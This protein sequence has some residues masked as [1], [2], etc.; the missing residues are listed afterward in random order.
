MELKRI[1]DYLWEIPQSGG[2]RV[3]GR[4][5]A[6]R[7]MLDTLRNDPSLK[8]VQNVAHLPGIVG[9]SL[10]MP[11]IH[12]GYGFPIGGVAAMDVNS[13]VISPG[14]VGYDI[15]CGVRLLSIEC[16]KNEIAPKIKMLLAGLFNAIPTGIGSHNA[17]SNIS[18]K[19][20]SRILRDGASEAVSLGYGCED[21]LPTI[22]EGGCLKAAQPENVSHYAKKRGIKQLGTLG[23]GNHFL[24]ID[25]VD[26]IYDD[27]IAKTFHLRQNQVVII[28]HTGSR[29]LGHQVCDDYIKVSLQSIQRHGLSLPDRQLACLPIQ[30]KEGGQYIG[31]M[32]SAANFAFAN[33][34]II[35][36][37]TEQVFLQQLKTS[38]KTLGMRTVYDI[39]HNIAKRER[40]HHQ[41]ENKWVCVHRKG[42]T[43]AFPPGHEALH[44]DFRE[45]GQPVII[46][47]DMGTAS[48]VL[49]GTQK[50]M[51]ETFGSTCHGAGRRM[52]R[53]AAK[54]QVQGG[55][56][57]GQLQKQGIEIRAGSLR[58]LAEEAPIAYKDVSRVVDVVHNASIARKVARLRP[59]AV[60]KG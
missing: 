27:D 41:G 49:A 16:D 43:R 47:G 11:D 13:G 53:R 60:V 4:I 6:N 20:F 55:K 58:G 37:I 51:D 12:W 39:C 15:N 30:S 2:M 44:A 36:S 57:K 38:P 8:Q 45:T 23:S 28:I 34:Q 24:E 32:R 59:I 33:R 40:H 3:P 46:P 54:R 48:Y 42:A 25:Y 10:A 52:S 29:G 14:G 35:K 50:A 5:Y 18:A 19:Q 31:A 22:E 9:Y 7:T 26:E 1:H 21:D 17:I 56:L